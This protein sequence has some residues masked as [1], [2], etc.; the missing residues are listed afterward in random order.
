MLSSIP[1][2]CQGLCSHP[3]RGTAG[4]SALI[5][6]QGTARVS[7]GMLLGC[8]GRAEMWLLL[9][10][11]AQFLQALHWLLYCSRDTGTQTWGLH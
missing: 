5:H 3:S 10:D 8:S 2:H 6:S 7:A 1:R 11:V 9:W 4:G